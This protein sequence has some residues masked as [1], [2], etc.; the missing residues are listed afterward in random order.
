MFT[1]ST[2]RVIQ[3]LYISPDGDVFERSYGSHGVGSRAVGFQS[4]PLW[5]QR[6]P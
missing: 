5:E 4:S 1:H 6:H 3:D 2:V